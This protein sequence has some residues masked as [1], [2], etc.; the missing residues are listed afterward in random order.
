MGHAEDAREILIEKERRQRRAERARLT[1]WPHKAAH[2]FFTRV[3]EMVRY[4]HA[5]QWALL[6]AA[7]FVLL[8]WLV[9]LV[10][11]DVMVPAKPV[12]Q[13]AAALANPVPG[14]TATG[15]TKAAT[16]PPQSAAN[17]TTAAAP[18]LPDVPFLPFVYSLEAFV[19]IVKLGQI[20]VWRP[21]MS[22]EAGFWVQ[23]YFWAHGF[24]GWLIGGVAVAGILGLFQRK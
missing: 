24:L 2:W 5:P 10:W 23:I 18:P 21:D 3:L 12:P 11:G 22:T 15:I 19:P 9:L 1:S 20:E 16:R 4:G 17:P 13:T 7:G 8:G 14:S 6:N